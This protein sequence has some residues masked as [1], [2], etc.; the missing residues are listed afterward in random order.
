MGPVTNGIKFPF[1][2]DTNDLIITTAE[3]LSG[4]IHVRFYDKDN[5][6]SGDLYL[7]QESYLIGVCNSWVRYPSS[8]PSGDKTWKISYDYQ[9]FRLRVHCNDK[10]VLDVT[11][12]SQICAKYS[13]G[14]WIWDT[15][16]ER[17]TEQMLFSSDGA[18]VTFCTG[19]GKYSLDFISIE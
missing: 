6:E 7:T 12:N 10:S 8:L 15:Y 3:T 14:S 11:L 18:S 17:K 4:R 2:A 16:W 1:I 9:T 19:S 13:T 5:R